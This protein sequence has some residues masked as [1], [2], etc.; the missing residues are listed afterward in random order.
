MRNYRERPTIPEQQQRYSSVHPVGS[1]RTVRYR[2][3]R[4]DV[5]SR[6]YRRLGRAKRKPHVLATARLIRLCELAAMDAMPGVSL[7]KT[8]VV[9]HK[10][11][12]VR[13]STVT[14]D[15]V[16]THAEGRDWEWHVEVRDEHEVIALVDLGFVADID[17]K[18]YARRLAPKLAARP[19][20]IVWWLRILDALALLVVVASPAEAVY[21]GRGWISMLALETVLI[22][23]WLLALTGLPFAIGDWFTVRPGVIKKKEAEFCIEKTG[24][25]VGRW[26]DER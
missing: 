7:G 16:C 11:P 18:R 3:R 25:L 13:G 2:V 8:V 20:R 5:A 24:S 12:A 1:R 23:G 15:A 4:R 26:A 6:I 17:G 14:V 10:A 9:N 19:A 21:A 22:V